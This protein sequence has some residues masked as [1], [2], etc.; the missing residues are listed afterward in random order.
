MD[1]CGWIIGW[2]GSESNSLKTLPLIGMKPGVNQC[3]QRDHHN[4]RLTQPVPSRMLTQVEGMK[5]FEEKN[6]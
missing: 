2:G 1:I 3:Q 6:I 4:Q 5:S